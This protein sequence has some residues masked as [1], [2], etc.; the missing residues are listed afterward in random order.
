MQISD[1]TAAIAEDR[2]Y[3]YLII[4]LCRIWQGACLKQ[5]NAKWCWRVINR[6]CG[7]IAGLIWGLTCF[8]PG[9]DLGI[10]QSGLLRAAQSGWRVL[11]G[12][13]FQKR[14]GAFSPVRLFSL[15]RGAIRQCSLCRAG[16]EYKCEDNQEL[17]ISQSWTQTMIHTSASVDL[18]FGP[19]L[20]FLTLR[21]LILPWLST[22]SKKYPNPEPF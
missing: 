14:Y 8:F 18:F 1:E 21:C 3:L 11:R 15:T 9:I 19:L 10:Q 4:E 20:L 13:S 17:W 7:R 6:L 2:Y 16:H 12:L 22:W 5:V